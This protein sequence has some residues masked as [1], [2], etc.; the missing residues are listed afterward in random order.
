MTWNQPADPVLGA[1]LTETQLWELRVVEF[2][3]RI[4]KYEENLRSAYSLIWGQCTDALREK[5]KANTG[6]VIISNNYQTIELMKSIRDCVY[7]FESQKYGPHGLHESIRRFYMLSQDKNATCPDYLEKFRN[8]IEVVSHCGGSPGIHPSRV[9]SILL[10]NGHNIN[11]TNGQ[12]I[13]AEKE[14]REEYLATA[15]LLSS[16]R[17]RFGKLVEDIENDHIRGIDKYPKTIVDA[18]SLLVHWKQDPKNLI[19]IL[20]GVNNDRAAFANVGDDNPNQNHSGRALQDKSGIECYHCHDFGHYL[21]ECPIKLQEQAQESG[22]VHLNAGF[23][24][25][26]FDDDACMHFSFF[27]G[28]EEGVSDQVMTAGKSTGTLH[29]QGGMTVPQN[30]ILLDNQ[31]T[32]NVFQTRKCFA[33]FALPNAP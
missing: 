20:G 17:K 1:T 5:I 19:R 6:Y 7:K 26:D 15:L 24:F 33:T 4:L 30:W 23:D 9:N 11:T 13:A 2:S 3:K 16:D 14:C 21:N 10:R 12:K 31:S 25:D 27:Q 8:H 32:V 22:A 28:G 29:H 18:Y